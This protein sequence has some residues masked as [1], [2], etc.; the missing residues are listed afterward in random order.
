VVVIQR[1]LEGATLGGAC[2]GR[3]ADL[4][5]VLGASVGGV[6]VGHEAIILLCQLLLAPNPPGN[7]SQSPKNN[8]TADTNDDT[9]DG[10]SGLGRHA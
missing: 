3:V 8:S 4:R 6:V 1:R 9:D 10:V 7:K 2:T 5:L